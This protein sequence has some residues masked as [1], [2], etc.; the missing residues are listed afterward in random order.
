MHFPQKNKKTN[1]IIK[2]CVKLVTSRWWLNHTATFK[3]VNKI[4]ILDT[5]EE[6]AE[7]MKLNISYQ[8]QLKVWSSGGATD[9]AML[10]N[11]KRL[12]LSELKLTFLELHR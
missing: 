5:R 8:K 12:L 9:E 1:M 10:C 4:T 7:W 11:P 2:N 3:D 6:N